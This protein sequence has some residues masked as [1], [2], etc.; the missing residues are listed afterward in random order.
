MSDGPSFQAV[1]TN[2]DSQGTI[3]KS[4]NALLQQDHPLDKIIV[5]D[6]GSPGDAELIR[7]TYPQV[8]LIELHENTGLT[9]AR[10]VGLTQADSDYVLLLDDDVYPAPDCLGRLLAAGIETGAAVVCPRIVSHPGGGL[11]QCDGAAIHFAAM[12][13]LKD[14]QLPVAAVPAL[15]YACNAFIGAC[16]LVRRQVL[17]D[18]GGFDEDYFFYFEDLELSY[19]LRSLGY[20]IWC[21]PRAVALHERG[22]GT[23]DLSFRGTGAYPRRRAYLTLRHRWL[24]ILLHYRL[25]S[26]IALAPALALYELAAFAECIRR[27]W[28]DHWFSAAWSLGTHIRSIFRR[29][30][31]WQ[32]AR[33]LPDR[34]LL[35]GGPLPFAPG[36]VPRGILGWV[37]HVLGAVLNLNWKL[38]RLWI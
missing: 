10:N 12:L 32:S 5:V 8:C 30:M 1:I 16:L 38:V 36:F 34:D 7:R 13:V 4:I 35:T 11:I 28:V 20:K 3:L 19:R 22:S 24:T 9:H 31:K 14:S 25:R 37:I 33:Q 27:G 21:E 6:N 17:S 23:P 18:L 15:P 2:Y 29:R 26:L